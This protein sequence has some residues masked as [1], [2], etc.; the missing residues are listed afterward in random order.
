MRYVH[1]HSSRFWGVL[2]FAGVAALALAGALA[3]LWGDYQVF[4]ALARQTEPALI[5]LFVCIV[6]LAWGLT[7]YALG[8]LVVLVILAAAVL[9]PNPDKEVS[10]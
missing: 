4:A 5:M 9:L 1:S 2:L 3:V 10:S 6:L 7:P 8:T